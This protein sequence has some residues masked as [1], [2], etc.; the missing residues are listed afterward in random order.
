MKCNGFTSNVDK[1]LIPFIL[2]GVDALVFFPLIGVRVCRQ[3]AL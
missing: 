3:Y 2:A 1:V